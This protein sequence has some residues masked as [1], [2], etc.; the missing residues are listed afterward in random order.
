MGRIAVNVRLA[1]LAIVLSLSPAVVAQSDPAQR[2]RKVTRFV[3]EGNTLLPDAEVRNL[4]RVYEG[5]ELT[6]DEMK[7]AARDLTSL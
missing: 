4:L 5:R 6:L 2:T 1:A 3:V 7:E